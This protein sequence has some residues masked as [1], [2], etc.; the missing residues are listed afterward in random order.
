MWLAAFGWSVT[1][2]GPP[3][4]FFQRTA[5]FGLLSVTG[6][7]WVPEVLTSSNLPVW[8]VGATLSIEFGIL[9]LTSGVGTISIAQGKV[10]K[11]S[12]ILFATGAASLL[13]YPGPCIGPF[14]LLAIGAGGLFTI[15]DVEK[16]TK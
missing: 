1:V 14:L 13:G 12:L 5:F 8:V 9:L 2:V 10:V 4:H 7:N 16:K 11:G 3:I 15:R 6:S